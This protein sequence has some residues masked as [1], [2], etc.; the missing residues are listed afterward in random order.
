MRL[1]HYSDTT[2]IL[3]EIYEF[4]NFMVYIH[5]QMR[6]MGYEGGSSVRISGGSVSEVG[7]L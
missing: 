5:I 7:L 6:G 4:C 2:P 3:F 1:S